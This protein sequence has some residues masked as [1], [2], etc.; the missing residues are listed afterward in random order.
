MIRKV[1]T[2]EQKT[3]SA[4]TTLVVKGV[5]DY[6]TRNDILLDAAVQLL[7]IVYTEKIREEKG[8]TYNVQVSALL[9]HHP[10]DE[11]ILRIAFQT[12]PDKYASLM[13]IIYEQLEK[14]ATEG[15]SQTD[16]D[17]V[18][19]Y[20]LKVYNQVLEMNNYWELVLYNDLYNGNDIDTDFRKIVEGMTVEDVRQILKQLLDQKN[21]IEVTMTSKSLKT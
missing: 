3:P 14:M 4:T 21:R 11:A 15:P 17:K 7:R 6:N 12:D 13:P 19:A 16:L 18:K 8:G 9:Q 20:E 2:K 10:Y 1:F 5:I